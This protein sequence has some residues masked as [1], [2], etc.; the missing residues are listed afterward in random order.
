ML[1]YTCGSLREHTAMQLFRRVRVCRG[2]QAW[3]AICLELAAGEYL[4]VC[5]QEVAVRGHVGRRL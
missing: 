1:A 2:R 3:H 4:L 5:W